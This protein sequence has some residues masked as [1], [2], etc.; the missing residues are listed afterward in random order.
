MP[1]TTL[2]VIVG[3]RD[4]FPDHLVSEARKEVL[5]LLKEMDVE[6]VIL[7]EGESKL[8]GV[9]TYADSK[10]CADLFLANRDRL[11][12]VLVTL[13]N[14]GDE[15]GVADTLR[16]ARLDVPVLVHAYP[17]DLGRMNV[18]TR[19]DAFCGKVS[20]CN[21]LKQ[22]R[23]PFSLTTKHV[24]HPQDESF[25]ND[26]RKFFSV[27]RVVK[28]VRKARIGAIGARPS[29]FNTVRYSEKVLEAAGI[30]VRTIDLSD[31]FGQ[32]G[33]LADHD[34]K[35]RQRLEEIHAY[36][37]A[38]TTPAESLVRMAKLAVVVSDW[39]T[40]NELDGIAFQCWT[41]I[42]QNYGINPCTVMSMMS[43]KMIPS[44]CEV[45]ITG[46]LSMYV[47]QLA[48]NSPSAL[49]D[50]N[51]NYGEDP[52]KCVFFHCGNWARSFVPEV[53][54]STAPILGTTVGVKNTFGA[55]EGR[56][57]TGPLTYGRITT[58]DTRG[59]IGAYVGEGCFTDDELK[60]FG[61]RAVVEVPNL[62]KLMRHICK[63]GFEHHAAMTKSHTAGALA[64]ALGT[65]LK[66]D[67]YYHERPEELT[68][69]AEE[70]KD[71]SFSMRN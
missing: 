52:N 37:E 53:K 2:G 11:D 41:S 57:S 33:K 14:F 38:G 10:R 34:L 71:G 12:G 22:Y 60:T 23:I 54:I 56:A 15:R 64:E 1:T 8:G 36:A 40:S 47:L 16:L 67:V 27:C 44:A 50:W 20:V 21:N 42:Q 28:G 70:K 46:A 45:D 55:M 18:E 48:S 62:E 35:V 69:A 66:W 30:S 65:Y 61:M 3:N 31:V 39:I 43:E 58:E 4:F 32:A 6:C 7:G 29:A 25:K 17:D 63:S 51:N 19:R 9:E 68:Q 49:V 26:L 5:G 13:P 59:Q 24:V